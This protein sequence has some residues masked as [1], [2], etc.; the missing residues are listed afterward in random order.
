MTPIESELTCASFGHDVPTMEF[1]R[2]KEKVGAVCT[3]ERIN[4]SVQLSVSASEVSSTPAAPATDGPSSCPTCEQSIVADEL[5]AT[6]NTVPKALLDCNSNALCTEEEE[7]SEGTPQNLADKEKRQLVEDIARLDK[8]KCELET[9]VKSLQQKYNELSRAVHDAQSA[10][11]RD[12]SKSMETQ[13]NQEASDRA[14]R[15][16]YELVNV[17]VHN[18]FQA[19]EGDNNEIREVN[20]ETRNNSSVSSTR[21]KHREQTHKAG[22]KQP[23]I[24]N[25]VN[26]RPTVSTSQHNKD[27]PP[28]VLILGD[29]NTKT[30]KTDVMYP[31]KRVTKEVTYNLTQAT[32]YIQR[33]TMSDPKVILFHVGTN[34]I[35]DARD[36][37][38]V[39]ESFRKL[40]Q[41]SHDK[42]PQTQL[43]F[44]SILPRKDSNLQEVGNQVNT[45][46][47]VV[48]EETDYVHVTD[49]SNMM[50]NS[51]MLK[52]TLYN[53][54]GYHLN[55]FGVRVLVANIKRVQGFQAKPPAAPRIEYGAS[56][57]LPISYRESEATSSSTQARV[58]PSTR[59]RSPAEGA[60]IQ[61]PGKTEEQS[62]IRTTTRSGSNSTRHPNDRKSYSYVQTTPTWSTVG[63]LE[64]PAESTTGT[65]EQPVESTT[66]TLEQPAESATGTLEQPAESATM[67]QPAESATGT[68][69][70]PAESAAM[71]QSA[72][73]VQSPTHA[74][75]SP[76]YKLHA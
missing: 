11:L 52:E 15:L 24:Q 29:S 36:P 5:C 19:L 39:S 30:V 56:K 22:E 58:V 42:F 18:R 14:E 70:Q 47:K 9:Q 60:Y 28:D 65:L 10:S 49:N 33:S 45:F 72:S 32:E 6:C 2:L 69:E 21:A 4:N 61:L 48:A 67:G 71:E 64:Q 63:T 20:N 17:N 75:E 51:G 55:R 37:T 8:V 62:P 68:L 13:T 34:D 7:P 38:A 44:S 40:I 57:I 43:V 50:S 46:L 66:G 76:T 73:H 74:M 25:K 16:L 41:T 26:P 12:Q 23:P 53:P 35:R 31:A 3:S 27:M 1:P 54:D 59:S